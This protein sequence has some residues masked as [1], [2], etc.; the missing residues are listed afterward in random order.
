VAADQFALLRFKG[1]FAK[2]R[3]PPKPDQGR[4]RTVK[5]RFRGESTN[6]VDAKGRVS[7]PAPFRRVLEAGDPVWKS[8]E[9]PEMVIVYGDHRRKY[10]ECYT[11]EAINEVGDQIDALPRGSRER[12]MLQAMF[13]GQSLPTSVDET[14]RLVLPAKLRN[15]IDLEAEAFFIAAGDTFQIWKPETYE[16]EELADREAWLDDLPDD[17][18]PLIFLNQPKPE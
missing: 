1:P 8:G 2:Q 18:D 17:V 3:N 12:K 4:P 10:L 15:K 16:A 11:I 5:L 7:I 6:K 14:G 13:D 9:N